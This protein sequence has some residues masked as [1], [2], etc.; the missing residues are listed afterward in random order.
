MK[1]IIVL[2]L[3]MLMLSGG[4]A[5]LEARTLRLALDSDPETLDIHE[6]LS[7][8]MLAFSHW[9]FD[10]LVRYAQDM[11][12]EARLAERW[13]RIDDLTMR[14]YLRKGVSF[15]SGNPFTAK[16]VVFTVKRLKT[17]VDF[18][19][20]FDLFEIPVAVDDYTVD[21]KTTKP[22]PLLLN[23]ATYIFPMDS[24]YYSGTDDQG[25]PKD[26]IVK[27]KYSFANTHLPIGTGPF[28]CTSRELGVKV[29]MERF[30]G[31][32][33]KGSPGNIDEII[34]TPIKEEATR[35]AALL[36]GDV[37]FISPVPPQDF[38]RVDKDPNVNLFTFTGGRIITVQMNQKRLAPLRV[39]KVRRAI[40]LA[41]NNVGI[42]KK[43]M[44]GTATAAGQLSPKGY[45][46]YNEALVPRYDL[47]EARALM[48]DAGYGKGFEATMIAPNNR[49]VNDEKI[50]EAFVAMLSKIN[51]KIN[52]KTMPKAQYWDEYDKQVAD[53]QM[54][55]W[56]SDTEDSGNFYEFL[57]MC[58][59][60]ETGYG[61]YNS[62]N[63]C[64]PRVD[65]LTL[66]CQTETDIAKRKQMLQE[67]ERILYDDAAFVPF[68]WQNHSYG[69]RKGID[70]APIINTMNFPYLGDLVMK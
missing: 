13:E 44:K 9:V 39:S 43:I 20:L 53:F 34:L 46:G 58:P 42:A 18:K 35:V 40:V 65:E 16:D 50:A 12:F 4:M 1:R 68:H 14:F 41:V 61:Q 2:C 54:V 56:H 66:A 48:R 15:H 5:A 67:I 57:V 21:I 8:P 47:K 69:A 27:F 3:V 31:Y 37:D 62:G 49:Y 7:G 30:A 33:D 28:R 38:G 32:W 29:V 24:V 36:S 55:G 22:Y 45:Q 59:N 52:L 11:S 10:P 63:Y 60:K 64:N 51:I 25:Q 6:Q 26:A 17:S 70:V 19:A 23:M